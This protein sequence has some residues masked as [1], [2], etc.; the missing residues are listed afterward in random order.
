MKLMGGAP[1]GGAAPQPAPGSPVTAGMT[2][3]QEDAGKKQAAMVDIG[4][5]MDLIEKNLIVFGSETPEG[6]T[7][8]KAL[9]SMHKL[10][11]GQRGE[12]KELQGAELQQLMAGQGQ[13]TPELQAMQG[14]GGAPGAQLMQM[15][16]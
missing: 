1:K 11:G 9:Q 4:M 14:A 3:P 6:Q 7:L 5:A 15:A 16:A 12:A 13:K 10:F 8:W 2:T